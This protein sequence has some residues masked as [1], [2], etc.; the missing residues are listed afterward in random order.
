M[1]TAPGI[2]SDGS[3]LEHGKPM[4]CRCQRSHRRARRDRRRRRSGPA[5]RRAAGFAEPLPKSRGL[6]L[7]EEALD[8]LR[9]VNALGEIAKR[10][11][12]DQ[13]DLA[14]R[15]QLVTRGATA[16]VGL[17]LGGAVGGDQQ[18]LIGQWRAAGQGLEGQSAVSGHVGVV[19]DLHHAA[20]GLLA[21]IAAQALA[22]NSGSVCG[23]PVVVPVDGLDADEH[24]DRD[25]HQIDPDRSPFLLAYVTDGAA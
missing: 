2:D 12:A 4:E 24:A 17:G 19:P 25:D 9:G 8:N 21:Q 13:P 22:E 11:I 3:P 16:N 20:P 18:L 10:V 23:G 7:A 15:R 14:P 1:A 5:G 6:A